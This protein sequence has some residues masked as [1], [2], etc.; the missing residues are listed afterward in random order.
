MFLD[1]LRLNSGQ[2]FT[3]IQ[4]TA[5]NARWTD[6]NNS[7]QYLQAAHFTVKGY[8]KINMTEEKDVLHPS[9]FKKS[10]EVIS[11]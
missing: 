1:C 11:N 2:V 3:V 4:V 8:P 5:D 9:F 6:N 10:K 7:L